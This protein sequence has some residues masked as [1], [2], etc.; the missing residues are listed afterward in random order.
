[1]Q[2]ATQWGNSLYTFEVYPPEGAIIEP[3]AYTLGDINEDGIINSLDYSMLSRHI[4][5]VS[6]LSGNQ[7]L[8][9]DLNGD[10]KIDSIDGS[11]LTRYLLEIIET[12]P[13][14]K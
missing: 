13:A 14:E 4:L 2:R 7:L 12:F 11:L 8:A 5:E 1:M 9:A 3:P 6:T 10:G